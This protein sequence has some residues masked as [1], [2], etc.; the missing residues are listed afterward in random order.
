MLAIAGIVTLADWFG[1]LAFIGRLS[2]RGRSHLR[3]GTA[4]ACGE[5]SRYARPYQEFT[6]GYSAG[7]GFYT[8]AGRTHRPLPLRAHFEILCT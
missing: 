7:N 2:A 3:I 6:P 1:R 5:Q 4:A 8:I